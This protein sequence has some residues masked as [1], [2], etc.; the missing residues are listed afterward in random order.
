MTTIQYNTG[1]EPLKVVEYGRIVQDMI[2]A[3]KQIADDEKRQ[4]TVERIAE[5]I[6]VL[7]PQLRQIEDY[8]T[9][10]WTQIFRIGGADL[11]VVAPVSIDIA[12]IEVALR[13]TPLRY[14]T[15]RTK[16]RHY[17]KYIQ[18]FIEKT[19]ALPNADDRDQATQVI[20]GFMKMAYRDWSNENTADGV[21]RADLQTLS[22]GRLSISE[23]TALAVPSQHASRGQKEAKDLK[24]SF[25]SA[26]YKN[27]NHQNQNQSQNQK[28]K[29]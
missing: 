27:K 16:I 4:A 28:R 24:E 13:P 22:G 6:I 5:T 23:D 7:H 9:Q 15:A 18:Q 17:G 14:A 21:I 29:K 8:K 1:A 19:A 3:A 25:R 10:V 2:T 26:K 11:N 12:T 20:G